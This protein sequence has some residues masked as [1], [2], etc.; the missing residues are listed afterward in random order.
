L[1]IR[2]IRMNDK[3]ILERNV[4]VVVIGIEFSVKKYVALP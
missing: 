1:W 4:L 3:K 2:E